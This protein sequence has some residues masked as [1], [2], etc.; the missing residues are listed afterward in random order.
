MDAAEADGG[1]PNSQAQSGQPSWQ[2]PVQPFLYYMK[3][4]R[5]LLSPDEYTENN[6]LC[7]SRDKHEGPFKDQLEIR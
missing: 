5:V 1:P 4:V 3:R 6:E 7:W 2:A